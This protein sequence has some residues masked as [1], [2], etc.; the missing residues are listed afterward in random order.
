[1][2]FGVGVGK[3]NVKSKGYC[4]EDIIKE[5]PKGGEPKKI[6]KTKDADGLRG[7]GGRTRG[8]FK[9]REKLYGLETNLKAT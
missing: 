4:G 9:H 7:V 3:N 5:G 6:E 2:E 8:M 1:M